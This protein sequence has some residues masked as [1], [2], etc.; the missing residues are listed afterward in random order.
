LIDEKAKEK[1]I[2]LFKLIFLINFILGREE[3]S[4]S[5]TFEYTN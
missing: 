2:E 5:T 3:T 1:V 4:T